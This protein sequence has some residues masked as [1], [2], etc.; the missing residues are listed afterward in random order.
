MN[1]LEEC[2]DRAVHELARSICTEALPEMSIRLASVRL[3]APGF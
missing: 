2:A 3:S 1:E